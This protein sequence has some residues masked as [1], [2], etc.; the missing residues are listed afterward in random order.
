[1]TTPE[2]DPGRERV[3]RTNQAF[4]GL[5]KQYSERICDRM[6][7]ASV[8]QTEL[9]LASGEKRTFILFGAFTD[10]RAENKPE[11]L[12]LLSADT[13]IRAVARAV[14][15]GSN[16]IVQDVDSWTGTVTFQGEVQ[17]AD[18]SSMSISN[19]SIT[20]SELKEDEFHDI[21]NKMSLSL[22]FSENTENR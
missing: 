11:V 19:T 1:M 15:E 10:G 12:V 13:N 22:R 4:A 5:F 17:S 7:M 20:G 16:P 6:G 3:G 2:F 14:W 8:W 21:L 18:Q 9:E